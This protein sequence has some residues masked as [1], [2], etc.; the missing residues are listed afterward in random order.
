MK[1]EHYTRRNGKVPAAL[2][3]IRV[4]L[5]LWIMFMPAGPAEA[6][7][8][9]NR[10]LDLPPVEIY[11]G[12]TLLKI[13]LAD[14]A[15]YCREKTGGAGSTV[16]VACAY[17]AMQAGIEA[18][19]GKETPERDDIKVVSSLPSYTSVVSFQYLTGAGPDVRGVKA[20]GDFGL[21]LPD[22]T[23]VK[24]A[25]YKNLQELSKNI[26]LE[27]YQFTFVRRSTGESFT[28]KVKDDVFSGNYFELSK[29]VNFGVPERATVREFEQNA[30]QQTVITERFLTLPPWEL[31]ED[32]KQPFP[33]AA[34]VFTSAV[35]LLFVSGL[36][37][38]WKAKK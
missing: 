16:D 21:V 14:V 22:G 32:I 3:L 27:N 26:S 18:L 1:C 23:E 4:M 37:Y 2:F 12:D 13:S 38:S 11:D 25:S 31:F 20:K 30:A 15:G 10:H 6:H 9:L 24:D 35:F 28:V 7:S 29:K 33:V 5:V 8:A 17:R 34:G 19:W 36:V